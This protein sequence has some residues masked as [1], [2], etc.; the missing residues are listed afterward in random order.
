VDFF[1][2]TITTTRQKT[3]CTCT[4]PINNTVF[5]LLKQRMKV[6]PING[7]AYVFFNGAGNMIDAGKLKRAFI[8]AVEA[9]KI[10]EFRFHD[11]AQTFATRLVQKGIDLYKVAKLLGHSDVSM[12][13]RYA[14]HYSESLRDEVEILDSLNLKRSSEQTVC[15]DFV[16]VGGSDEQYGVR[17]TV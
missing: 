17:V 4:I 7:S 6:R 8:A 1:R 13:Q 5:E 2:K 16:T 3:A 10:E 12:T 11:L 14:H 9:A 15:H